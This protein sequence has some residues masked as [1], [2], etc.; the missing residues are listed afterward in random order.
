MTPEEQRIYTQTVKRLG[1]RGIKDPT[2]QVIALAE[3]IDRYRNRIYWLEQRQTE[4]PPAPIIPWCTWFQK[5]WARI[6]QAAA[7]LKERRTP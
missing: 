6:Q 5:E 2:A 7:A 1:R 4:V 3:E